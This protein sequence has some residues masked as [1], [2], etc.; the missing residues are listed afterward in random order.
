MAANFSDSVQVVFQNKLAEMLSKA[1]SKN[2][3]TF[4][5]EQYLVSWKNLGRLVQN[6]QHKHLGNTMF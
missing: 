2:Y 1:N 4:S 6:R 3:A 5:K